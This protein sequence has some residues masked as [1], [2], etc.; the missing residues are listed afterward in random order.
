MT[1]AAT[2][3]TPVQLAALATAPLLGEVLAEAAELAADLEAP[4][5]PA[6]A[7]EPEAEAAPDEP[8]AAA[9]EPETTAD[10]EGPDAAALLSPVREPET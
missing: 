9:D 2:A 10:A 3:K 1:P 5:A 7:A 4:D 6:L 8:E